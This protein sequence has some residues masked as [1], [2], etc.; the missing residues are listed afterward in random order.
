VDF[1]PNEVDFIPIIGAKHPRANSPNSR[2]KKRP[3]NP[4]ASSTV[5]EGRA[6]KGASEALLGRGTSSGGLSNTNLLP[7]KGVGVASDLVGF[8][9]FY[10]RYSRPSIYYTNS[11]TPKAAREEEEEKEEDTIRLLLAK[12]FTLEARVLAL[13]AEKA[14]KP[15]KPTPKNTPKHTAY[16]A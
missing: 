4:A 9:P 6:A 8:N 11:R 12:V 15:T 2:P 16:T 5:R 1:I 13:E 10:K 14:F 3:T 7:F